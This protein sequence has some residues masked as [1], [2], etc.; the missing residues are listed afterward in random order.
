M[1]I[2]NYLE[3]QLYCKISHVVTPVF[4]C[5]K[6]SSLDQSLQCL[7]DWSTASVGVSMLS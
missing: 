7:T 6:W 2:A 4:C 5:L 1:N 3:K